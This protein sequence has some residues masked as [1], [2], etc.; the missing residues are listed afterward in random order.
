[1]LVCCWARGVGQR[2]WQS[3]TQVSN[4]VARGEQVH[5]QAAL[6]THS[7]EVMYEAGCSAI[8]S[9]V[10]HADGAVR[11]GAHKLR[12][13]TRHLHLGARMPFEALILAAI[14][15]RLECLRRVVLVC[16][17]KQGVGAEEI[18]RRAR[19]AVELGWSVLCMRKVA[20]SDAHFPASQC[21]RP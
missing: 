9:F 3:L 4:G 5:A 19:S 21:M 7:M 1:M 15:R 16:G 10:G 17:G 2:E 11:H 8:Q 6:T 12:S 20:W 14:D 13:A 18:S